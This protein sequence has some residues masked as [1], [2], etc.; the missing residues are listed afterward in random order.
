M[1]KNRV[2]EIILGKLLQIVIMLISIRCLTTYLNDENVGGYYLYNTIFTFWSLF[3]LNP[4]AQY[5]NCNINKWK[6]DGTVVNKLY[7]YILATVIVSFI[8]L[9]VL[10]FL[11]DFNLYNSTTEMIIIVCL[12]IMF[13]NSNQN[14]IFLSNIL[15]NNRFFVV[16]LV[17]TSLISLFLSLLFLYLFGPS[18]INWVLGITIGNGLSLFYAIY[19]FKRKYRYNK[20]SYRIKYSNFKIIFKFCIPISLATFFMWGLNSGYRIYVDKYI[21]IDYLAYLAVGFGV[22]LQIMSVLESL[23]TQYFQ[24]EF[25][26]GIKSEK[27]SDRVKN[28]EGYI[29]NVLGVY[30]PVVLFI[31][32]YIKYIFPLLISANFSSSLNVVY[33]AIIIDFFRVI[34]NAVSLIAQSENKTKL[35]SIPYISGLTFFIISIV[36]LSF[37]AIG[38]VG[39]VF[40]FVLLISFLIVFI[41]MFFI[42]KNVTSFRI[43]Y[44]LLF[45]KVIIIIPASLPV[46]L[47]D[48]TYGVSI[49]NIFVLFS[50]SLIFLLCI[51]IGY[52]RGFYAKN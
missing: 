32:C 15:N 1:T 43:N 52:S 24:P 14:I 39:I 21:G 44:K 45:K 35:L 20:K 19:F 42:M 31:F 29:D 8:A 13:V 41:V 37:I 7:I 2:V 9:I 10:Y 49:E 28:I 36:F 16:S 50:G 51:W 17:F 18:Y 22:S 30:L 25:Y 23:T 47:F 6:D 38:H 33:V 48:Y 11:N 5:Y 34:T 46:L 26:N 40:P 4:L 27:I 12:S 3:C